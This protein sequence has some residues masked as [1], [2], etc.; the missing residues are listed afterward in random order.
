MALQ[1]NQK[2]EAQPIQTIPPFLFIQ[3]TQLT[4]QQVAFSQGLHHPHAA[5]AT[6]A[7]HAAH[8]TH[9]S[10]GHSRFRLRLLYY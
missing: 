10:T 9:V 2:K 4:E 5:H 8:A 6:H 1:L 7:A 3:T